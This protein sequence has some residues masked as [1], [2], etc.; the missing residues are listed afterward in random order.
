MALIRLHL[1]PTR[2]HLNA[3]RNSVFSHAQIYVGGDWSML[4]ISDSLIRLTTPYLFYISPYFSTR[5][6]PGASNMEGTGLKPLGQYDRLYGSGGAYF[7]S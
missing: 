3:T 4:Q 7:R 2:L 6:F 1:N 5:P